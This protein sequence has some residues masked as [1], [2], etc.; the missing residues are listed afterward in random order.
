M[1]EPIAT[2]ND[3]LATVNNLKEEAEE[4]VKTITHLCT[5]ILQKQRELRDIGIEVDNGHFEKLDKALKQVQPVYNDS[6]SY[7]Y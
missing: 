5:S 4:A 7:M 1:S 3:I 6:F 2:P